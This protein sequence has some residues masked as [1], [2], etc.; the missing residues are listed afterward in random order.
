MT[1]TGKLRQMIEELQRMRESCEPKRPDNPR[2]NAYS[3]AVSS[4]RFV[5][6][7]IE[8]EEVMSA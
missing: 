8:A 5:I 4:I 2:Y 7:D 6:S 1:D 3:R